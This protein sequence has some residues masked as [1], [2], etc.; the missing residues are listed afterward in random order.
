LAPKLL[1]PLVLVE[2]V[3]VAFRHLLEEALLEYSMDVDLLDFESF[4]NFL[5]LHQRRLVDPEEIPLNLGSTSGWK[6]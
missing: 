5:P 6:W 4:L 1:I 2:V 3:V